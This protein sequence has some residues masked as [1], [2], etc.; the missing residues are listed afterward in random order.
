MFTEFFTVGGE[1]KVI[2]QT[3]KKGNFLIVKGQD[4]G[5]IVKVVKIAVWKR[6]QE[7]HIDKDRFVFFPDFEVGEIAAAKAGANFADMGDLPNFGSFS[8]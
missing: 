5:K 7:P 3:M 8:L 6:L 4:N 1:S 2:P